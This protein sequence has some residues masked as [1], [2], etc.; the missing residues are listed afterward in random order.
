MNALIR[1]YPQAWRDRY[2]LSVRLSRGT[3]V[4]PTVTSGRA[5]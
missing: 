5:A 4:H 2:G 1:L 3:V